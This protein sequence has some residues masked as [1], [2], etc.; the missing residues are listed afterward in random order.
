MSSPTKPAASKLPLPSDIYALGVRFRVEMH[1][2]LDD[3]AA[4]DPELEPTW[5]DTVGYLRRIRISSKQDTR[6]QWT[7]LLHEYLHA[8]LYINGV[9]STIRDDVEEIIVQSMEHAIEQ[10][11]LEHG[12]KFIKALEVQK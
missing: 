6:R 9:S 4:D 11:M 3:G 8:V 10:F 12:D 5:G 2:D 7:T 1:E